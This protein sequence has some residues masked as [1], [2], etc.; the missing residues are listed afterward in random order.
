MTS[1]D[2]NS[3]SPTKLHYFLLPHKE[4]FQMF[5]VAW[6]LAN[7]NCYFFKMVGSFLPNLLTC[8][9]SLSLFKQC[10]FIAHRSATRFSYCLRKKRR[11]KLRCKLLDAFVKLR[12]TT[13][14]FMSV[15]P[16]LCPHGTTRLS[17]DGF[18]WNLIFQYFSN[19]CRED[20]SFI[21]IWQ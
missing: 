13:I 3:T 17:L 14:R 8:H 12:K 15:R 19:I 5:P 4:K 11:K 21:K 9:I 1:L 6:K 2:S 7:S 20:S 10:I 18:P 16:S